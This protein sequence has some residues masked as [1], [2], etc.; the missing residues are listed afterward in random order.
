MNLGRMSS[1]YVELGEQPGGWLDSLPRTS[2]LSSY[3][4][5]IRY[6]FRC[7]AVFPYAYTEGLGP[8]EISQ[9]SRRRAPEKSFASSD[10][11]IPETG[12]LGASLPAVSESRWYCH[13]SSPNSAR[14]QRIGISHLEPMQR[15]NSSYRSAVGDPRPLE[16]PQERQRCE[17]PINWALGINKECS[18]CSLQHTPGPA[19][20]IPSR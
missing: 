19:P 16:P 9:P 5:G 3:G 2:S 8:G 13:G 11:R 15:S 7:G 4:N 1:D 18:S 20:T 14:D 12:R 10:R 17:T 6:R